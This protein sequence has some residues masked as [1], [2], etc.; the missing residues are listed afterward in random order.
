ML[1]L[2]H[3][4][5]F[6]NFKP[7]QFPGVLS[8]KLLPYILLEKYIYIFALGMASPGNQHCDSCIGI[9]SFHIDRQ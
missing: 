2:K 9:L 6:A 4:Q 5:H 3:N 7:Q 1:F 8:I